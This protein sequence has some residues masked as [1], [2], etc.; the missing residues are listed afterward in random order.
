[1]PARACRMTETGLQHLRP[2]IHRTHGHSRMYRA[3]PKEC[4]GRRAGIYNK[5]FFVVNRKFLLVV[6]QK[7]E[8][9]DYCVIR[10]SRTKKER[11]LSWRRQPPSFLCRL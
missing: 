11:G 4:I 8:G 1:M 6:T 5:I 7:S 9:R 2:V 3:G 10:Q